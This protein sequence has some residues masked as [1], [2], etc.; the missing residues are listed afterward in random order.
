MACQRSQSF[1]DLLKLDSQKVVNMDLGALKAYE[2]Q[3]SNAVDFYQQK[4]LDKESMTA[5]FKLAKVQMKSQD[6]LNATVSLKSALAYADKVGDTHTS[7]EIYKTLA[8]IY[9]MTFD[10]T[11]SLKCLL[12]AERCFAETA[13]S[14]SRYRVLLDVGNA[15]LNFQNYNDAEKSLVKVI[16][17]AKRNCDTVV[18]AQGVTAWARTMVKRSS[19][20]Y[21]KAI[22]LMNLA[23]D[24]YGAELTIEDKCTLAYSYLMEEQ[25]HLSD[26]LMNEAHIYL[27]DDLSKL[28]YAYW[29]SR[30]CEAKSKFPEAQM[31]HFWADSLSAVTMSSATDISIESAELDYYASVISSY[32]STMVQNKQNVLMIILVFFLLILIIL[33]IFLIDH[34]KIQGKMK[35]YKKKYDTLDILPNNI[36]ETQNKINC[37]VRKGS[38]AQFFNKLLEDYYAHE[39]MQNGAKSSYAIVSDF[40]EILRKDRDF[41]QEIVN[42]A[43]LQSDNV[44]MSFRQELSNLKEQDYRFFTFLVLGWTP[45]AIA[46][47][48]SID[49]DQ[50]YRW[51]YRLKTK[52][53]AANVKHSEQF[54]LVLNIN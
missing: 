24:Q 6:F 29:S 34:A 1:D 31:W 37:I 36:K 20:N 35:C 11:E 44:V 15:Y 50:V 38:Q 41:Y 54:F 28:V 27:D 5:N 10:H 3:L 47:A 4:C 14:S 21:L 13:D 46:V 7:G 2:E 32:Q 26:S 42:L 12:R 33:T 30:S 9:K 49:I 51:K 18:I 39:V 40:I 19:P 25:E 48:M 8:V 53:K 22:E 52:V 43:N 23:I 17:W 16:G 45:I